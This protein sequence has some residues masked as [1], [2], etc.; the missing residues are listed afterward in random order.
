MKGLNGLLWI[1]LLLGVIITFSV[2]VSFSEQ[3]NIALFSNV[4][5]NGTSG[6]IAKFHNATFLNNSIIFQKN[7]YVG[8]NNTNPA[9]LLDVVGTVQGRTVVASQL[10]EIDHMQP[11]GN[12]PDERLDIRNYAYI[13]LYNDTVI[14]QT[15]SIGSEQQIPIFEQI[16]EYSAVIIGGVNVSSL[17]NAT[18]IFTKN[19]NVTNNV[20]TNNLVVDR[21]LAKPT[22]AFIYGN[23]TFQKANIFFSNFLDTPIFIIDLVNNRFNATST[24]YYSK[25]FSAKAMQFERTFGTPQTAF[26]VNTAGTYAVGIGVDGIECCN[27]HVNG[28]ARIQIPNTIALQITNA[29]GYALFT[30]DTINQNVEI[31]GTTKLLAN[32]TVRNQNKAGAFN[33]SGITM[34]NESNRGWCVRVTGEGTLQAIEGNC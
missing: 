17:I 31:N 29:T 3:I 25:V 4:S 26:K 5:A 1:V 32:L 21:I 10:A 22:G 8:I 20:S 13:E 6:F 2:V 12:D 27:F 28:T 15:L 30:A 14:R 18:T 33:I 34:F 23:I 19:I 11:V 7:Q 16:P 24:S 9:H